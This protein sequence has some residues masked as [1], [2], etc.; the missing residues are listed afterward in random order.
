MD[1]I[2]DREAE[3][4]VLSALLHS[5]I[6]C[7]EA[8]YTLCDDDFSVYLHKAIYQLTYSLFKREITPT[9]VEVIKEGTT[10]GL[11]N[12]IK[13]IEEFRY[14]AEQYI[15]DSNINYWI[16]RVRN[17]S[18]SRKAQT[19]INEY[20]A[21]LQDPKI[22]IS[23][24]IQRAGSDFM[25]LA[26]DND[27]ERIED[28][29][30]I[31]ALGEALITE[32]VDKWRRMQD[33]L[34]FRGQVPLEGVTTGLPKLDCLTLGYK[35]GDLIILAA[36]T[37]HGK[38]AFALNTAMAVCVDEKKPLL[39]INTEMSRKQI[40]FRWGAILSQIPFQ[41]IRSGS[42]TNGEL[43]QV[44]T[45]FNIFRQSQFYTSHM[46]N[47]TPAKLQTLARKAKMQYNIEMLILD[48]VG[49]MEKHDPKL[50]EYQVLE[51]I[52]KSQKIM[53]QNLE[54]ACM[55]LVQLNED[56]SLQGAKRMKN[57]CDVMLKLI[58]VD[59]DQAD[60]IRQY[61]HKQYED[62]NYRLYIEKSRDSQAGIDIPIV[63]DKQCQQIREA[64]EIR[65]NK[66]TTNGT[67]LT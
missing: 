58:P 11:F 17:A 20:A 2:T 53:A 26:M 9:C 47:L 27:S 63:F 57:E 33:N 25:A 44:K 14:I 35:P 46:P 8:F 64:G 54:I 39:Y 24:L 19:F 32:K 66:E 18:T 62:F 65:Q 49:R 1:M 67:I 36:Q 50:Q 4:R 7:V 48:Y 31:A 22:N 12:G 30:S 34:K 37:G 6:A 23:D 60:K 21:E 29:E 38:T 41:K 51:Q 5:E 3:R 28:A 45:G 10:L 52:V 43:Y 15:D 16:N 40:A 56:G 13:D 42:L 59:P 61:H 55:V